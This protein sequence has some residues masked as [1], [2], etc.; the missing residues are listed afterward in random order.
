LLR[1][2]EILLERG[3]GWADEQ[4]AREVA[5]DAMFRIASVTK[6]VTAALVRSL[7]AAGR[8]KLSD[9]VFDLA[10]AGDA[11][12]GILR[13]DPF[14]SL[15]DRRLAKVTVQHC[16]DH[17]AGWDRARAGDLT[18][19]ERD[20]AAAMAVPSPP[21]REATVRWVLGQPLQ[22]AP[23]STKAYSNIGYL[24]LGLVIERCTGDPYGTCVQR[25]FEQLPTNPTDV[26][27]GRTMPPDRHPREVWYSDLTPTVASVIDDLGVGV[28]DGAA[29]AAVG[30]AAAAAAAAAAVPRP[31]GGFDLEARASQGGIIA[32]TRPL[33]RLLDQR[34][35]NG[36]AIGAP[37]PRRGKWR[38][39]HQGSNAGCNALARQRGVDG[40]CYVVLFNQR[41]AAGLSYAAQI[42]LLLDKELDSVR[43]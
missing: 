10:Q 17:T 6:P 23:G 21:G 43:W 9:Y 39:N 41:P 35:I 1:D 32:A 18:Y 40:V 14:P 24:V 2:G 8:C 5:A 42:K 33:L 4:R 12:G 11:G 26:A 16:L 38:W 37:R 31:Y 19:R 20:I 22:H 36:P 25:M 27:L 34:F 13:L 3:Y 15:S 29:A 28:G 7:V 30:A